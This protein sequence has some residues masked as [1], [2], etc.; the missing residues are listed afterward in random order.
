MNKQMYRDITDAFAVSTTK[1][2]CISMLAD[3]FAKAD[4]KFDK[5]KFIAECYLGGSSKSSKDDK[6]QLQFAFMSRL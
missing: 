1:F 5:H 6:R 3:C 2:E 4:K